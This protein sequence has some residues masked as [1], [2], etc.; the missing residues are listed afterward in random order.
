MKVAAAIKGKNSTAK[1]IFLWTKEVNLDFDLWVVSHFI[2]L[3]EMFY[4]NFRIP[5]CQCG[6]P[7]TN[8]PGGPVAQ[9]CICYFT[10]DCGLFSRSD[11]IGL[12]RSLDPY[13]IIPEIY[14]IFPPNLW[15]F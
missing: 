8:I 4:E 6:E 1:H 9:S 13:Q 14:K 2:C 11:P 15:L 5:G 12:I 3:V 7:L 10:S